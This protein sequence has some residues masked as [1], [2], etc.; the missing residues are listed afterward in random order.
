MRCTRKGKTV[1]A[2][3][4][5]IK[6]CAFLTQN[7]IPRAST[8]E[9]FQED[10]PM[11]GMMSCAPVMAAKVFINRTEMVKIIIVHRL[12]QVIHSKASVQDKFCVVCITK[13]E[14]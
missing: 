8:Q 10:E 5:L 1:M 14:M 9:P 7:R 4:C 12:W 11:G 6:P 2:R 13:A 3:G